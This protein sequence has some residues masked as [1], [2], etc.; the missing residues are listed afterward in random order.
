MSKD[1]KG[2]VRR[3]CFAGVLVLFYFGK[4]VIFLSRETDFCD[5]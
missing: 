1:L 4:V 5:S 3:L 2:T